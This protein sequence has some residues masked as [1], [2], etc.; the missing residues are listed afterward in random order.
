MHTCTGG[1]S[2][3]VKFL[4]CFHASALI[5]SH[6]IKPF[7]F[8]V[9]PTPIYQLRTWRFSP[10]FSFS[11]KITTTLGNGIIFFNF[12][13]WVRWKTHFLNLTSGGK[14]YF[15][16]FISQKCSPKYDGDKYF[17]ET[18]YS[19]KYT[20]ATLSEYHCDSFTC[21]RFVHFHSLYTAVTKTICN[22]HAHAQLRSIQF[23]FKLC[24]QS[25]QL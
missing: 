14:K 5:I 21:F 8:E 3:F 12:F 13:L 7:H 24:S 1:K 11:W 20:S 17:K 19:V 23:S 16:L 2:T 9:I 6:W 4:P 18:A 22:I 25:F 15:F 10:H